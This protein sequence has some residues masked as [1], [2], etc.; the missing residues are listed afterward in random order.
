[1]IRVLIVDDHPLVAEG[2][3]AVLG[4]ESDIEVVG[5]ARTALEAEEIAKREALHVVMMDFR[6]PD[7]SGAEAA[8]AIRD[9]QPEV[10]VVFLTA[11]VSDDAIGR[12]VQAGAVGFL[13]KGDAV[14]EIACAIRRAAAGEMLIPADVLARLLV[15]QRRNAQSQ[16]ELATLVA[17][18]TPRERDVLRLMAEGLDNADI[19][20]RLS[21][22]LSTVR[23]HI[24]NILEKLGV[25][26]KLAAVL[27]ASELG[28]VER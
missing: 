24:S 9:E 13:I 23:W 16:A 11:D 10:A 22:E 1:V 28:L 18:F 2:L 19:I 6:L 3:A 21:V 17:Q 8:V 12:A 15:E 20:E 14:T 25:H 4:K 26:S 27:R 5:V 7:R